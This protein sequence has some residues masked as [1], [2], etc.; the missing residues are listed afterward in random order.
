MN[1][2]WCALSAWSTAM[3]ACTPVE[4]VSFGPD[5]VAGAVLRVDE[6][7]ALLEA[8]PLL[9]VT[10]R[11]PLLDH[12]GEGAVVALGWTLEQV[13]SV[14]TG[15]TE[16]FDA[17]SCELTLPAPASRVD[18]SGQAILPSLTTEA[19]RS[20]CGPSREILLDAS[21][22]EGPC[23]APVREVGPCRFSVDGTEC[24]LPSLSVRT[25][26][27][28]VCLT[29]PPG[30]EVAAPGSELLQVRCPDR[31]VDVHVDP[32]RDLGLDVARWL[33]PLATGVDQP[34]LLD[35]TSQF[36]VSQLTH[37]WLAGFDLIEGEPHVLARSG[38]LGEACANR[39]QP[40]W[41]RLDPETLDAMDLGEGRGCTIDLV[42]SG[43]TA[44]AMRERGGGSEVL[45][46]L[47]A[48]GAEGPAVPVGGEDNRISGHALVVVEDRVVVGLGGTLPRLAVHRVTDLGWIRSVPVAT[49]PVRLA[50]RFGRV[51]SS[52]EEG[53]LV[54]LDAPRL[55]LNGSAPLAEPSFGAVLALWPV[56]A[57]RV[58][59]L[60]D[61]GTAGRVVDATRNRDRL[62]RRTAWS[63]SFVPSAAARWPPDPS[64]VLV[65]GLR[66]LDGGV[67]VA[68]VTLY[69]LEARRFRAPFTEVGLGLVGRMRADDRGHVWLSLPWEGAVARVTPATEP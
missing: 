11:L 39:P 5:V 8:S 66:L 45:Y 47:G 57:D 60:A 1:P 7:G 49:A 15:G 65:G 30:C 43:T 59:V 38:D 55:E 21:E 35:N 58:L 68:V 44:V 25:R 26:R 69:D 33:S 22:L 41:I 48:S 50:F 3:L 13:G 16:L 40:R 2:R 32:D 56:T 10:S 17:M 19:L 64:L 36:Q 52:G 4:P 46:R 6:A 23:S 62:E 20:D 31:A 42:A 54:W 24:G 53:G 63:M 29:P 37:G 9:P 61:S 12:G 18:L 67:R 27:N 51:V 14:P 28:D 34:A